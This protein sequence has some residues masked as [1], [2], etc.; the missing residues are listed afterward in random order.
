MG[1]LAKENVPGYERVQ[2]YPLN[3][4]AV[5]LGELYGEFDLNSN[6]WT[7]GILSSVMRTVCSNSDSKGSGDSKEDKKAGG[8]GAEKRLDQ[9]WIIFDGPVDTLW[10]ES[11]NS[12]MDDNK[13]LTLING[14]R[15]SMPENVSLLFEVGDL[16]VAS[17]AT[18]SRCGMVY[19]DYTDL[20]WKPFVESWLSKKKDKILVEELRRLIEKYLEKII[21]FV[22]Q[23]CVE[24]IA[25]SELNGV[26]S[27][28][29]LFDCLATLD[30]GL[31][32]SDQD[33]Y[34]RMIELW[35]QFCMIWSLCCSVDEDGRKK[36]DNYI[37]EMEGTFPNKDTIY[38]YFV[39]NKN[40]AWAHW[41]DRL[42]S[43]WKYVP[44][45]PFHKIIVPTVDTVRYNFLVR[46]LIEKYNPVMLVG[47]VGTGKTSAALNALAKLDQFVW[48]V[49]TVNMS[50]QT[51]SN[52]VQEIIESE[53]RREPRRFLFLWVVRK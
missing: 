8:A 30:N 34:V 16:S 18:V 2:E 27:F 45:T 3:P 38:E 12:V 28:C 33:S 23:N 17:P 44:G 9:K 39:D 40:K 53:L 29:K 11:M 1:R 13:I 51:T 22:R 5:T 25:I 4:K 14:E 47:P 6:E 48:S 43:G 21:Q 42:R 35:F 19:N 41:E 31:D 49:L 15:I 37:R 36:I 26:I 10:I 24:L 46:N 20:G 50:A 52:Q 32:P 7:D